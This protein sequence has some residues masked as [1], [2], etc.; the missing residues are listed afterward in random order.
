VPNPDNYLRIGYWFCGE[1]P[2][3]VVVETPEGT[4]QFGEFTFTEQDDR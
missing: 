1:N 3:N 2:N 4:S